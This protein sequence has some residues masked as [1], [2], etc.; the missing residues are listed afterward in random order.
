MDFEWK[1]EHL[2]PAPARSDYGNG[3]VGAGFIVKRA[4]AP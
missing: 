1:L 2:L 3:A 4:T